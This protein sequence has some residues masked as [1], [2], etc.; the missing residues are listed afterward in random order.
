MPS[1][2]V[3]LSCLMKPST[4]AIQLQAPPDM[5]PRS[6]LTPSHMVAA[7]YRLFRDIEPGPGELAMFSVCGQ[8][9]QRT[10]QF[11]S[12]LI[13]APESHELP[14]MSLAGHI[15]LLWASGCRFRRLP[16]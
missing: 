14:I 11:T 7:P 2:T 3:C 15:A 9:L 4:G 6:L 10:D 16:S 8:R 1:A 5:D 12:C 13:A